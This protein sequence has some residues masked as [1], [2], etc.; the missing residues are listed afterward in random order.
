MVGPTV[1]HH[2]SVY[3]SSSELC[4][5]LP[6]TSSQRYWAA[7]ATQFLTVTLPSAANQ[8]PASQSPSFKT[9]SLYHGSPQLRACGAMRAATPKMTR[10]QR[11]MEVE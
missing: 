8:L 11:L 2:R 9:H 1:R 4:R 10:E 6:P 5:L 7:V 3:I